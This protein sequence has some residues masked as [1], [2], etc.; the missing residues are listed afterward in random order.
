MPMA[1][2][3]RKKS[4]PLQALTHSLGHGHGTVTTRYIL[5]ATPTAVNRGRCYTS[6]CDPPERD[7]SANNPRST[8]GLPSRTTIPQVGQ[9]LEATVDQGGDDGL[10]LLGA[11]IGFV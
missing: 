9:V 4:S 1:S 5:T 6:L 2:S 10:D 11:A 7:T 3:R 8:S